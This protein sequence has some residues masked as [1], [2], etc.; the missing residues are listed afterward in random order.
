MCHIWKKPNQIQE[1]MKTHAIWY[2]IQ[3]KPNKTELEMKTHDVWHAIKQ[4]DQTKPNKRWRP[5]RFNMPLNKETKPTPTRCSVGI[6][7]F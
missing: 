1:D 5:M 4:R 7:S 3:K 2:A 6:L